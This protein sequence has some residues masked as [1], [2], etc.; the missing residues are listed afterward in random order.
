MELSALQRKKI[1]LPQDTI[2]ISGNH[3][4]FFD[5]CRRLLECSEQL[6]QLKTDTHTVTIWGKDMTASDYSLRGLHIHGEIAVIE[7]DGGLR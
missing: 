1:L 5:K 3:D 2:E 4:I 7:F 6:V